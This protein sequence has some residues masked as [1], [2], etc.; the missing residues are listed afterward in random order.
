[1]V[2][3]RRA[4]YVTLIVLAGF[5]ALTT[6]A[7]GIGLVAGINAPPVSYLSGSIFQS[8][9]VPGLFLFV[10]GSGSAILATVLLARKSPFALV[11]TIAAAI[12]IMF[13][14]FVEVLV[15]GSPEGVAQALQ[16]FYF[17]L[18]TLISVICAGIWFIDLW[19]MLHAF[20][21]RKATSRSSQRKLAKSH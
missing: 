5:L 14:E 16:I 9:I 15:I 20:E 18:G 7:G 21:P 3:V 10:L 6:F 1:M 19:S 2:R 17:G 12:I 4:A 11:A 13:F 8:Y